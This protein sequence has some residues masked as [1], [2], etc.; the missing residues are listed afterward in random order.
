MS[1][2]AVDTLVIVFVAL[3]NAEQREALERISEQRAL[4]ESGGESATARHIRSLRLV[5]DYLGHVPS[6]DEYKQARRELSEAGHEVESFNRMLRHFG[7]W[8]RAKEAL[9]MAETSSAQRIDA[10]YRHRR[11][12]KVW[13][14][15]EA[16]LRDAMAQAVEYYGRP[17]LVSEYDWWRDR[18]LELALA[19]G[20]DAL[21]IPSAT[22]YRRRWGT[23]EAALLHFGYT[24]DQLAE[25]LEQQ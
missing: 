23:W 20:N 9:G 10:R 5:A 8:R 17:P 16:T 11:V 14:F 13:R 18:A 22:P 6:V 25:R 3:D 15:T 19:E 2:S 24:S 12:G 7:S 21:H 4:R 1:T